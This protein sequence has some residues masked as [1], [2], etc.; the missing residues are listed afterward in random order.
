MVGTQRDH[1][2]PWKSVYKLHHLCEAEITFVLTSG[3]HNAGIIS[4]PGHAKRSYQMGTRKAH[5]Q[6]VEPTQWVA[7]APQQEGSW[8]T[9]WQ[10]W[11]A[12]H[13][14]TPVPATAI[15]PNTVLCDAPG[16][17]VMVCYPE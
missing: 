9:A 1:I 11:L 6:W 3:G 13:S 17:Y 5:G 7:Q 16:T 4:E 15:E 12:M 14:S 2:S 10:Q 8:W